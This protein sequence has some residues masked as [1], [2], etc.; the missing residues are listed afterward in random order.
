MLFLL[1]NNNYCLYCRHTLL[2]RVM[3][4]RAADKIITIPQDEYTLVAKR[5]FHLANCEIKINSQE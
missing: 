5:V 2:G 1:S 3:S 4:L